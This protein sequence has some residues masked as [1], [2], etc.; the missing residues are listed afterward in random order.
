MVGME[1]AQRLLEH[2]KRQVFPASMRADLCHQENAVPLAAQ[3]RP[4]PVFAFAAMIFP[5]IIEEGNPA[6]DGGMC[7]P[8]CRFQVLEIAQVMATESESGNFYPSV[9]KG[10]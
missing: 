6:I 4:H 5:A 8:G 10:P 3:C 1:S 2:P 7:N 9:S